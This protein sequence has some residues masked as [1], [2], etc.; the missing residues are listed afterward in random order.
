MV[1][2][3]HFLLKL[4]W[5][6]VRPLCSIVCPEWS[7]T[8]RLSKIEEN[9]NPPIQPSWLRKIHKGPQVLQG[10]PKVRPSIRGRWMAQAQKHTFSG[11][12]TFFWYG[13]RIPF[14]T[15]QPWSCLATAP[16]R[17]DLEIWNETLKLTQEMKN[18]PTQFFWGISQIKFWKN[19]ISIDFPN[20][21]YIHFFWF[22][23][24]LPTTPHESLWPDPQQNSLTF[25]VTTKRLHRC[26]GEKD[27]TPGF[28]VAHSFAQQG[29]DT[30][31]HM[32]FITNH[33][34]GS[35]K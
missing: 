30:S 35:G 10:V 11:H 1:N 20:A 15:P 21:G 29:G 13:Y 33:L 2:Q 22:E 7:G 25:F 16:R 14:F 19:L 9:V 24:K 27:P 34:K 17:S 8:C 6:W 28:D 12:Q 23:I 32:C 18:R 31:H 5:V 26:P 4:L 3:Y